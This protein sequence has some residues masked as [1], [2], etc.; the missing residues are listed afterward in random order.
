MHN[1]GIV[2]CFVNHAAA[3]FRVPAHG[4]HGDE[5]GSPASAG[6]SRSARSRVRGVSGFAAV[7]APVAAVGSDRSGCCPGGRS[8][9]G[10]GAPSAGWPPEWRTVG[11]RGAGGSRSGSVDYPARTAFAA[12]SAGIA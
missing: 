2:R 11:A 3:A 12:K 6:C 5:S 9:G 10:R 4:A 1:E 8:S 7:E